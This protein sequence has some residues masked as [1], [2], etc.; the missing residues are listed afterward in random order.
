MVSLLCQT[1][2]Q[3]CMSLTFRVPNRTSSFFLFHIYI[4]I[5]TSVWCLG[6]FR[7]VPLLYCFPILKLVLHCF[8]NV[9]VSQERVF[10]GRA[11]VRAVF[12]AGSGK[13]AG[14]MVTEGKLTKGCGVAVTRGGKEQY[15]GTLGS[16][17]RVKEAAKE[18][19]MTMRC[20]EMHVCDSR[21]WLGLVHA[22]L[23]SR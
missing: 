10:L 21:F 6:S 16:L 4:Y 20:D 23:K 3:D 18:V 8:L 14:C 15:V 2:V 13:V 1:C 11:E 9:F 5:Y 12:G 7:H 19:R 22:W 17:R